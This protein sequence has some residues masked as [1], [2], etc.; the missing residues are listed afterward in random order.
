M[1]DHPQREID[2]QHIQVMLLEEETVL[3]RSRAELEQPP[4]TDRLDALEERGALRETPPRFV[5]ACGF[6]LVGAAVVRRS[7]LVE[8]VRV[9]ERCGHSPT[10]F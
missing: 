8:D 9:A 1:L 7:E 6:A 5:P 3:A 2:G 4:T 10:N